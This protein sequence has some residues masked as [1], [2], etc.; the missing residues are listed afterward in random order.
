MSSF[1]NNFNHDYHVSFTPEEIAKGGNFYNYEYGK[2]Y[3]P[4]AP[5]ISVFYKD[6]DGSIYHTYSCYSRGLDM[7]N[8]AYHYL[9]IVPKGRDESGPHKMAWVRFH[10]EYGRA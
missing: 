4:E 1:E 8:G 9:D 3:P 5:G 7:L 2:R 6:D 10:D